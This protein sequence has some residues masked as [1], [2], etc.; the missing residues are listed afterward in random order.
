MNA[1]TLAALV[2]DAAARLGDRLGPDQDAR[3]DAELLARHVLGW[4]AETWIARSRET[5]P[6]GFHEPFEALVARRARREPIAYILGTKE[7][8]GLDF[9]VTPDVLIPRPETELLVERALAAIDA[10]AAGGRRLRVLDLGTG[11]GCIAVALAHERPG[12]DVV[13]IDVSERAIRVAT[14]NAVRHGVRDRIAFHHTAGVFDAGGVDLVVSNPPYIAEG[15]A[16]DLMKD[17]VDFEPHAALFA[18]NDGLDVI[19]ATLAGL[20]RRDT[21]PPYIF[22][23]GGNAPAVRALVETSGFRLVEVVNDLAGIPRIAVVER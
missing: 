20:A 6:A 14:G 22:E 12:I 4:S 8:W 21:A 1:A 17:V 16:A 7:F 13:A 10:I 11:S 3:F 15:D 23:F 9:E 19:R 18:G 2:R 5:P